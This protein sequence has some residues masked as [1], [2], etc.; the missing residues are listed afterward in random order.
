[1]EDL[2]A[3]MTHENPARRPRIEEVLERLI[4]IRKSLSKGKLRSAIVSRKLPRPLQVFKQSRQSIRT[5]RY[6]VSRYPPIP[7]PNVQH[8]PAT[9][10][11][12]ELQVF[13]LARRTG[14]FICKLYEV[15]QVCVLGSGY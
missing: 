3:S 1:M 12:H 4:K 8:A 2:V 11:S 7:D 15:L 5:T 6:I 9:I 13:R 14:Q 10:T